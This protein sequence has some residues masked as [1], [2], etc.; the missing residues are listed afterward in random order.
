MNHLNKEKLQNVFT[1]ETLI[2]LI[3]FINTIKNYQQD[4][5]WSDLNA[6]IVT[7][8]LLIPQGMAYALLAG[9]PPVYGLYTAT[10]P[11]YTAE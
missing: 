7:F 6:G 1:T 4:Y 9:L 5:I 8:V 10:V 3:P 2:N 11:L